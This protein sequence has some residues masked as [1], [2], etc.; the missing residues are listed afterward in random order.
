MQDV[1]RDLALL[2]EQGNVE[3]SSNNA[4]SADKLNDLIEDI[5]EAMLEY[6][7]YIHNSFVSDISDVVPD[8]VAARYLRQELSPHRESHPAT[9]YSRGPI[10]R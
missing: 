7:A 10:N 3:G 2:G 4:K 9:L 8:F 1:Y 5:R 6:Q